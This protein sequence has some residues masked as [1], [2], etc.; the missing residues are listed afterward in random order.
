MTQANHQ[1][2]S[3][4]PQREPILS[5]LIRAQPPLMLLLSL[6]AIFFLSLWLLI[7]V[8]LVLFAASLVAILILSLV[9]SLK[10]LPI[11]GARLA[12]LP[13]IAN[14]LIVTM[15]LLLLMTGLMV[16][17]G[18]EL[19]G[20]L[21]EM[22]QALPQAFQQLKLYTQKFPI[23]QQWLGDSL[24][25]KG[26]NQPTTRALL[27]KLSNSIAI[28]T[29]MIG[30]VLGGITTFLAILLIGLFLA[31]SPSIYVRSAIR[32]TPIAHRERTAYLMHRTYVALKRWL[33]G[34]FVIMLFV[35]SMT[36]LGLYLMK[37]PFA[38]ALG[39]LAFLLDFVPVL[40]PWLA[41]IPLLLTVLLFKPDMI[42][43]AIALI[44][45]V[46]QLESYVVAPIVQN[47]LVDLAP[48]AL[49]LS[50]LIMGGL[51]GF[52]GIALATPLMV[53]MI[54]WVQ[55]LYVK[56]IL[57]DY[58][59]TVMGQSDDELKDDPFNELPNHTI[60]A[61]DI[62]IDSDAIHMDELPKSNH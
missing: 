11:I 46:Q 33:F 21:D 59:I 25:I 43:W 22:K 18:Q 7:D 32:L 35:G 3:I 54:V 57:G 16:L 14:A 9:E 5:G 40:G 28:D 20:Q 19:V 48:V 56:F 44:V 38:L 51:T 45:V 30:N 2:K 23:L 49:L 37:I 10:N 39:F 6:T 1:E 24:Q 29:A 12:K 50:Q 47:K 31:I 27:A 55:I 58:K 52:L 4:L 62:I 17:F 15:G 13:H 42:M 60:Y 61:N 34:Q 26:D 36:A 53:M 8:W 41:A